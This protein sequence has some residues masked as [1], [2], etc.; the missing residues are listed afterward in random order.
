MNNEEWGR[1]YRAA[2][3]GIRRARQL[4]AARRRA[5]IEFRKDAIVVA[6]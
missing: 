4:P 3:R 2:M 5:E 6:A 1:H